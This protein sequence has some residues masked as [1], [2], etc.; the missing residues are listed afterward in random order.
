MPHSAPRHIQEPLIHRTAESI[1]GIRKPAFDR[2]DEGMRSD[3]R[4]E[5]H[6]PETVFETTEGTDTPPNRVQ[7][8]TATSPPSTLGRRSWWR[9]FF[10]FD[11]RGTG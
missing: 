11:D 4:D 5:P 7:G 9:R 2:S 1:T 10:G 3:R 8:E 6:G